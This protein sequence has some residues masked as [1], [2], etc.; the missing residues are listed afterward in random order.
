MV[1]VIGGVGAGKRKY[2]TGEYGFQPGEMA[3]GKLD[4]RPVVYNLQ[5][6]LRKELEKGEEIDQGKIMKDLLDKKVVICDE[7]G[8]GVVPEK[9]FE[10]EWRELVGRIC[11]RLAEEA[12]D[13]V[14]VYY[15]I[16]M[17]LKA[18]RP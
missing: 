11:T 7:V 1:L 15:G 8:C 14:R 16:P 10:R 13:V 17:V 12:N 5:A 9:A 6:L 3:D 4:E 2:V 18:I